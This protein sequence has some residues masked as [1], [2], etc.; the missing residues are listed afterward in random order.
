[1]K[2]VREHKVRMYEISND[3]WSTSIYEEDDLEYILAQT[4]GT[5]EEAEDHVKR[6][7]KYPENKDRNVI[8]KEGNVYRVYARF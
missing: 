7:E 1:M 2:K 8:K 6:S 3:F 4:Y 5:L